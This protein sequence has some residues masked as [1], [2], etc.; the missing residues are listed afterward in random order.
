M[1]IIVELI[2][3]V[4]ILLIFFTALEVIQLVLDLFLFNSFLYFH[5][6]LCRKLLLIAHFDV[7]DLFIH[8]DELDFGR[9]RRIILLKV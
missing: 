4:E 7:A 6:A 5:L 8:H 2:K 9:F 3:V 1:I